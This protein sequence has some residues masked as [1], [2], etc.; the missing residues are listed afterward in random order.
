M[1]SGRWYRLRTDVLGITA[2][3]PSS[4]PPPDD[5]G[6]YYVCNVYEWAAATMRK[7]DPCYFRRRMGMV[8]PLGPWFRGTYL[9]SWV[10]DGII[11]RVYE[12]DPDDLVEYSLFLAL[13]EQLV[14]PADHDTLVQWESLRR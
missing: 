10:Y 7:G 6:S 5:G 11:A 9:Y 3:P 14:T 8:G 4:G 1:T 12:D 13:G 2:L